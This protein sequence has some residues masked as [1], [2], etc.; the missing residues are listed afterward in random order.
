M[1]LDKIPATTLSHQS[2]FFLRKKKKKKELPAAPWE[3]CLRF[4]G[5]CLAPALGEP[6][7]WQALPAGGGGQRLPPFLPSA[8]RAAG[9]TG[10]GAPTS[11]PLA[12]G[13]RMN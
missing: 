8:R 10:G 2:F 11:P 1:R 3:F 6:R 13:L 12:G 7:L 9:D 5:N 4:P